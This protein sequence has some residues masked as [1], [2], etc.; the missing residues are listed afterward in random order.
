MSSE[1]H[2]VCL[3]DQT[4]YG[5]AILLSVGWST[6]AVLLLVLI[7]LVLVHSDSIA[8]IHGIVIL[9]GLSCFHP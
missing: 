2:L 9:V 6:F 1:D 5:L 3:W 8:S 4:I 7:D